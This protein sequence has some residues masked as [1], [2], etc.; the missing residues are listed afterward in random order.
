MPVSDA[1]DE[2]VAR[3][4]ARDV[5]ATLGASH[6]NRVEF[7]AS[8]S[9]GYLDEADPWYAQH[10]IDEVQQYFHDT[11]VDTSWP[12]CPRHSDHPLW[13]K[14][15]WWWCERDAVAVSK[16]GDLKVDVRMGG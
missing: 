4:L 13:F 9:L 14:D 5:A 1:S 10:L 15:G 3:L 6:E 11:R 7:F 2:S 16:L 8:S 12:A